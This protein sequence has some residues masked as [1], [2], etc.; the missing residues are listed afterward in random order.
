MPVYTVH[1]PPPRKG[2]TIPA[3]E[4]FM[5]VREGFRLWAF[6]LP[7][8][9]LLVRRLWLALL[10][11]LVAAAIILISLRF[12]SAPGWARFWVMAIVHLLVG[13]E[14]ATIERWTFARSK[15][16][17]IGTVSADNAEAAE[18]R[19]FDA[20]VAR[21]GNVPAPAARPETPAAPYPAPRPQQSD[22]LGLFPQPGSR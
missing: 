20:W 12:M 3:P 4:R 11:Y 5:F 22:V 14:A 10:V 18:R 19:F 16:K 17:T 1:E 8:L 15:W 13:L 9:W 2:E 6:L 21:G 7:P